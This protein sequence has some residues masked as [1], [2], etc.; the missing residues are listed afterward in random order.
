MRLSQTAVAWT[1]NHLQ[2][3]FEVDLDGA[4]W[5]RT[6]MQSKERIGSNEDPHRKMEFPNKTVPVVEQEEIVPIPYCL[7]KEKS[8]DSF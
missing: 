1:R 4:V 7:W 8:T 2:N 6:P 5:M 3:T